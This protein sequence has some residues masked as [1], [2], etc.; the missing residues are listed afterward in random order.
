ML[1]ID[2]R[3]GS[4]PKA[5]AL[6]T[7]LA[8]AGIDVRHA[9]LTSGDVVII[10]S[11]AAY[12]VAVELKKVSDFVNSMRSGRLGGV[13]GQAERMRRDHD[14]SFV[15]VY[16]RVKMSGG[17]YAVRDRWMSQGRKASWTEIATGGEHGVKWSEWVKHVAA[18]QMAKGVGWMHV[19]TEK[20]LAAAVEALYWWVQEENHST[21]TKMFSQQRGVKLLGR[22]A[23]VSPFVRMLMTIDGIGEKAAKAVAEEFKGGAQ[24]VINAGVKGLEKRVKGVGKIGAQKILREV[25]F[26][27]RGDDG[28][29]GKGKQR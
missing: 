29:S 27:L 11:G 9:F 21:L 26:M 23:P 3:E 28:Q 18:L 20:E 16:G 22:A 17:G 13:N 10:D 2:K 5:A 8:A 7:P 12:T 4:N 15:A 1:L 25:V 19:E 6:A 24:E 14:F